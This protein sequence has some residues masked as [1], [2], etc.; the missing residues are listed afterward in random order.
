M[1]SNFGNI[2]IKVGGDLTGKILF[3]DETIL[4][5]YNKI[6]SSGNTK[7]V[8]AFKSLEAHIVNE[9]NRDDQEYKKVK[10]AYKELLQQVEEKKEPSLIKETWISLVAMVP[11]IK[12]VTD[13]AKEIKALFV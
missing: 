11:S 5:S 12:E 10:D 4:N 3:G 8:E 1:S 6:S 7:L 2:E 13:I 9:L